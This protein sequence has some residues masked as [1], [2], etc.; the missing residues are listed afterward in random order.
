MLRSVQLIGRDVERAR[1]A[2]LLR[3]ANDGAGQVVLVAGEAGSGKTSLVREVLATSGFGVFTGEAREFANPEFG[4]VADL[5]KYARRDNPEARSRLKDLI[6]A[7]SAIVPG[8][9]VSSSA[10]DRGTLFETV[11]DAVVGLAEED[12]SAAIVFEDLHWADHATIEVLGLL[13]DRIE[14]SR[15]L[16]ACIFRNDDLPRAHPLRRL[17]QHLRR[18][19]RVAEIE[20]TALDETNTARLAGSVLGGLPG[21]RLAADLHRLSGGLPLYVE[22]LAL[23]LLHQQRV[24]AGENGYELKN[25]AEFPVP[26]S[27]R[28]AVLLRTSDL[29]APALHVLQN[30][31]VAGNRFD[32]SWLPDLE[33]DRGGID[34]LIESNL[35]VE[36][37][38]GVGRFRHALLREVV[39][40]QIPWTKRR[41]FHRELAAALERES[42]PP[43]MIAEHWLAAREPERARTIFLDLANRAC[44]VHAYADALGYSTRALDLWPGGLDEIARLDALERNGQ[45]AQL[46]GHHGEAARAWNEVADCSERAEDFARVGRCK[47]LLAGLWAQLADWDRAVQARDE[48]ASAFSAAGLP[49]DAGAERYAAA[50]VL[51]FS[52]RN[53]AVLRLLAIALPEAQAARDLELE[54]G[55]LSLQGRALGRTGRVEDGMSIARRALDMAVEHNL[56]AVAGVAYQ[57]LADCMEHAGDYYAAKN[58]FLTAVDFCSANGDMTQREACKG[59]ALPVLYQIGDWDLGMSM[60]EELIRD[61]SAPAWARAIALHVLGTLQVVRGE[62][63]TGRH[64]LVEA[65]A[66]SRELGFTALEVT[67]LGGLAFAEMLDNRTDSAVEYSRKALKRWGDGEERH[68]IVPVLRSV[69]SWFAMAGDIA[70]VNACARALTTIVAATGQSE[71]L[72]ALAHVM[73]EAQLLASRPAEAVNEFQSSLDLLQSLPI[74]F[75]RAQTRLRFAE[76]LLAAGRRESAIA[77]LREAVDGLKALKAVTLVTQAAKRLHELAP[78]FASPADERNARAG[79]T[80]RQH[81]I[82]KQIALGQTDKQIAR[83]LSLSPRTVEMHVARML[84]TL[85]CKSRAEAV[86]RAADLDLLR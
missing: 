77:Q 39:Y 2:E 26:E 79:L 68:H 59:C 54:I 61:P 40:G 70:G 32:L 72:S 75:Q 8:W 43:E 44:G 74:P 66:L 80:P 4:A 33:N 9:G 63:K 5:L 55:I 3:L 47:R 65:L 83:Q 6:P 20:L 38:P 84:A 1:M 31:A 64:N 49:G 86:G 12:R 27:L 41:N 19:G 56:V 53:D 82:L 24:K 52:A 35:L 46:A 58:T 81:E 21:A 51:N 78:G 48:A 22:E 73:G 57:R 28:E 34:E 67:A 11:T 36:S 25:D 50:Y 23:A 16:V 10:K 15:M 60:S 18:R 29:S 13:A 17:R 42:G 37:E 69:S 14:H 7:L 45:C 76:A 71:A 85:H 62:A 30:A